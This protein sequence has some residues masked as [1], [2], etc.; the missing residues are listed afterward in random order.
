LPLYNYPSVW[1]HLGAIGISSTST[2]AI[3]GLFIIL[4]CASLLLIYDTQTVA[5]G[6]LAFTAVISPPVLLGVERGNIDVL[7][8]AASV[9]TLYLMAKRT[10]LG[11]TVIQC[12]VIAF[13]TVLKI[14]PIAGA[15]VLARRRLGYAGIA[16]TGLVAAIGLL[17]LV[18]PGELRAIAQ[19]TPQSIALSYGDM[20]IFLAAYEHGLLPAIFESGALRVI[21][22]MTALALAGI[23]ILLSLRCSGIL[24]RV[25]PPLDPATATGAVAMSCVSVFCFSFLLG[26]NWDYR[27]VFLL[28]VLPALLT[29][30]DNERQVWTL[31]PPGAI[32][33]F[34][35]ASKVSWRILVPFEVLDWSL[36][37]LGVMWLAQ[38][39]FAQQT[40]SSERTRKQEH[41]PSSAGRDHDTRT[42]RT[43]YC[44]FPGRSRL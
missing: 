16:L 19:N 40:V 22:G 13:L 38:T 43:A 17:G 42:R 35:W 26:S 2:N 44:R 11:A 4:L 27:L 25:L 20:P 23:A 33:L 28:G 41:A 18:G 15:T 29:A 6:I 37:V 5:S 14:Y 3:G 21:A 31:V 34:L 32:V 7:I 24:R 9:M 30:H 1:L 12:G 39:V 36:F 10:G 8:F